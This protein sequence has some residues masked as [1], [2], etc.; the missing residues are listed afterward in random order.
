[1]YG[2]RD[3]PTTQQLVDAAA[4]APEQATALQYVLK[5]NT[6]LGGP[7]HGHRYVVS[8]ELSPGMMAE[9]LANSDP[10]GAGHFHWHTLTAES[11]MPYLLKA[12]RV[13]R[14]LQHH[15]KPISGTDH[16]PMRHR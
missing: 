13:Y 15:M 14:F 5:A 16:R 11:K 4:L 1:M 8:G 2:F 12:G 10:G 9:V 7:S 3:L 6:I